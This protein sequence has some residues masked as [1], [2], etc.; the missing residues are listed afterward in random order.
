[1]PT[2]REIKDHFGWKS[3][4]AAMDHVRALAKKHYLRVVPGK[5]RGIELVRTPPTGGNAAVAVPLVGLVPAGIP[6]EERESRERTILV[7]RLAIG[8]TT[9]SRLFAVRVGG[10][11]MTDR[12]ILDG[13][14][15]VAESGIE[16]CEGD[17]VVGLIDGGSSLKTLRKQRGH[18]YLEAENPR[19]S[20]LVPV[21]EM[22]IQ[23]VV[24]TLIREAC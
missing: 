22:V 23:G 16:A 8:T 1:M 12:G 21:S 18:F 6:T 13:D 15:V 9:A 24:R 3:P 17:V 19:Y 2:Y 14:I 5:A 7:D 4:K 10:D 11:S 20:D